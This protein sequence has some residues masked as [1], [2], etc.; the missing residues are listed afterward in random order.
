[1]STQETIKLTTPT[2][3]TNQQAIDRLRRMLD[4]AE[5]GEL[6]ELTAVYTLANGDHGNHYT[7]S[8]DLLLQLGMAENLKHIIQRRIDGDDF[9]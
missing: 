4:M 8:G 1:M 7:G 2:V 6:I 5:S 9:V 3:A